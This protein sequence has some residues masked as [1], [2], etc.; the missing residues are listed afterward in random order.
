MNASEVLAA[1][2][3]ASI[4]K[5]LALWERDEK[6]DCGSCGSAVMLLDA[7]S[8][9]AKVAIAE[10]YATKSGGDVYVTHF[11]GEGVRSQNAD[12]WQDS[13]R[14]FREVLIANGYEKAIKKFWTYID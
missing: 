5:S 1:A 6:Q 4:A 10:G 8:K 3:A 2:K 14:A 13:M 7:R 9:L 12:I 11:I